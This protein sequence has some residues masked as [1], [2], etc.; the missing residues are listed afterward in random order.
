MGNSFV[1]CTRAFCRRLRQIGATPPACLVARCDGWANSGLSVNS[2]RHDGDRRPL[3]ADADKRHL[4]AFANDDDCGGGS[5]RSDRTVCSYD[6]HY[7]KRHQEGAGL[8]DRFATWI[9]VHGVRCRSFCDRYLSCDDPRVFQ[10][11]HVPWRRQCYPW[12][13]SRTGHAADGR[14]QEVHALHLPDVSRRL[15]GNLRHHPF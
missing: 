1:D 12:D 6:W 4:P 7:S 8:F 15:A 10:S 5:W 11:A 3:H 2:C 14:A 13:A 9:H